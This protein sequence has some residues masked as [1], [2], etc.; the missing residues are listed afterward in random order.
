MWPKHIARGLRWA[1]PRGAS[2]SAQA[3]NTQFRGI[4]TVKLNMFAERAP[5]S[6]FAEQPRLLNGTL[7]CALANVADSA[8]EDSEVSSILEALDVYLR[9]LSPSVQMWNSFISIRCCTYA[10]FD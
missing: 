10:A 5:I 4:S 2:W 3:M 7:Q 6:G 8:C 1:L 9:S